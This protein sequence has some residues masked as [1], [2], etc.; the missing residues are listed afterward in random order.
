M[1]LNITTSVSVAIEYAIAILLNMS[2]L[3]S[4][5]ITLKSGQRLILNASDRFFIR[6]NQIVRQRPGQFE[7][8]QPT[9]AITD[10]Y[11]ATTQTWH[12]VTLYEALVSSLDMQ[13]VSI[14]SVLTSSEDRCYID[15]K[16]G[17]IHLNG[18][19]ARMFRAYR[20]DLL[21]DNIISIDR[22]NTDH[23]ALE[24]YDTHHTYA[25]R[26]RFSLQGKQFFQLLGKQIS[27][28]A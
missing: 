15:I 21:V 5:Y 7:Y 13:G 25:A 24:W 6:D 18:N 8:S 17:F 2:N 20:Y 19:R 28:L 12:Q 26:K 9:S 23:P 27:S 22:Y 14:V 4:G 3:E 1:I 11:C 16:K 10:E